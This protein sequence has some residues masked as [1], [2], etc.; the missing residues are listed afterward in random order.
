MRPAVAIRPISTEPD[1][2]GAEKASSGTPS[3]SAWAASTSTNCTTRPSRSSTFSGSSICP[4]PG[5][6]L[7][8]A[9]PTD[10]RRDDST[11]SQA[12]AREDGRQEWE[13]HF[14]EAEWAYS[15]ALKKNPETA[16]AWRGLGYLYDYWTLND[17]ITEVNRASG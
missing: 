15:R 12:F 6:T 3:S 9:T 2:V 10:T 8:S 16:E 17:Q 11:V 14:D 4:R 13:E 1:G 5:S 7:G